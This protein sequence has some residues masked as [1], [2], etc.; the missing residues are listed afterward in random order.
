MTRIGVVGH[1]EWVD[2]VPVGRLPRRGE[3]VHAEGA[4]ARAGGGGGVVATVLSGLGA[5]VDFFCALG[6]DAAGHAAAAQLRERGVNVHVA[7]REEPTRRA[8]T[9]LEPDG[10]RTII[11]LG[12]RLEP[13]GSD[14]LDWDR[15]LQ[16]AGVYFT[17]GDAAAL[18]NARRAPLLVASPR[19]WHALE[20]AALDAL[21]FSSRDE[22][23]REWSGRLAAGAKFLVATEG[24]VGG[25]WWGQSE[26]RWKPAPLPGHP[27]D[28]YGC[29]DSF[30]AGLTLGLA[31]GDSIEQAAALG[32]AC[33][34]RC[35]TLI[36]PP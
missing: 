3:V 16:V 22:R 19:G 15:L 33:G 29:G 6:D 26:G 31:R 9:L 20:G 2:F 30:A 5:E 21:V 18:Q 12:E 10:E 8:V 34:A 11:T 14:D 35:L 1:I 7:W 32:A 24:A 13:H 23:E 28:A 17:C 36:G 27:R 25:S 4:F